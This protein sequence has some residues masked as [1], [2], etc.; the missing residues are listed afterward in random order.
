MLN[1]ILNNSFIHIYMYIKF[2]FIACDK[3]SYGANCSQKCG[4][5]RDIKQCLHSNGLCLN[6]CKAGYTG[7]L[8]KTR[9]YWRSMESFFEYLKV[10]KRGWGDQIQLC[11]KCCMID[12]IMHYIFN[13][14][15]I[16]KVDSLITYIILFLS[17][18]RLNFKKVIDEMYWTLLCLTKMCRSVF[19]EKDSEICKYIHL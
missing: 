15:I 1:T 19:T 10:F 17:V 13:Y 9:K 3:G 4:N 2:F 14:L 18:V 7:S 6:G 11:P 12:L 8:C 16:F 5:C